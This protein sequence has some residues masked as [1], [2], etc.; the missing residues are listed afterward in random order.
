MV[1]KKINK[2]KIIIISII[3]FILLLTVLILFFKLSEK[4]DELNISKEKLVY[5]NSAE[6]NNETYPK[7][8]P[9]FV[10]AYSGKQTAQNLGKNVHYVVTELIPK[11][12]KNLKDYSDKELKEYFEENRE[13]ILVNFGIKTERDFMNLMHEIFKVESSSFKLQNF[14]I[15]EDSIRKNEKN[16]KA[17]L[18]VKYEGSNEISI[19]IKALN[20]VKVEESSVQYY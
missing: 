6:W 19:N 2:K 14:Y 15:D 18:Y 3:L 4:K 13:L 5:I 1:N 11:Y 20:D 8:M 10:R 16:T 9:A 7:G 17:V 12:Y